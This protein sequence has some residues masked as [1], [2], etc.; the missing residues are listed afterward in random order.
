MYLYVYVY[1]R[2]Y[3]HLRMYMFVDI[4]A[5]AGKINT[6]SRG[7]GNFTSLMPLHVLLN[8]IAPLMERR[9]HPLR[10]KPQTVM[11]SSYYPFVTQKDTPS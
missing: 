9:H 8:A 4:Y 7:E 11:G 2:V 3:V 6:V 1:V 10:Q 5:P